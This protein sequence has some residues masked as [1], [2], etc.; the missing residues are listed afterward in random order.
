MT[1]M[2]ST[3]ARCALLID[4]IDTCDRLHI[5]H[6][7]TDG[8]MQAKGFV[9]LAPGVADSSVSFQNQCRDI[10]VLQASRDNQPRLSAAHDDDIG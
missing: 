5:G 2:A 9:S 3:E 4:S 6:S 8:V 10:E 1:G 7:L